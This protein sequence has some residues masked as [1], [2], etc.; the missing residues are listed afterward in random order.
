LWIFGK[1]YKIMAIFFHPD[2]IKTAH[3]FDT[4][5][6]GADIA[7]Y[8][9]SRGWQITRPT[10]ITP[11]IATRYHDVSYVDAI[12]TGD[13]IDSAESQGFMWDEMMWR[14]V[15]AQNGAM[16]DAAHYACQHGRAY[17]LSAGFHHARAPHGAGFCTLNGL[18]IAA[19]EILAHYPNRNVIIVDADAHC[20]GGTMS[21]CA[22]WER[23]FHL[24]IHTSSYDGYVARAPHVRLSVTSADQYMTTLYNLLAHVESRIKPGDLLIYNAGM[25]IHQDCRIGGLHGITTEIVH[26]REQYISAWADSHALAMVACLAGGYEGGKLDQETL[27]AL[28]AMS[29]ETLL[30]TN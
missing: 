29:V 27:V 23:L 16:H 4:T 30:N 19:G 9:V 28:H 7:A 5:R 8:L 20:G 17:A 6:K 26:A 21:M 10:P 13:P 18:V 25:D 11:D 12:I 14:S 22:D 15:A 3:A 1:I 24:D 2:T